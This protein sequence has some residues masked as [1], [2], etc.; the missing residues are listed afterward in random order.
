[1]NLA[2]L[3]AM[4]LTY[5]NQLHFYTLIMKDQKEKSENPTEKKKDLNLVI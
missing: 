4:K 3:Q 5:R 1:M 2:K